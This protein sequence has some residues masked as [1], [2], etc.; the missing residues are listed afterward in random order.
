M[1]IS[2]SSTILFIVIAVFAAN[3]SASVIIFNQGLANS[4]V[5]AFKAKGFVKVTATAMKKRYFAKSFVPGS[6]EATDFV[7]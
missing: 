5:I 3:L 7:R 6:I 4:F 1:K 2:I